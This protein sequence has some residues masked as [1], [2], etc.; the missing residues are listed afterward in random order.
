MKIY[1]KQRLQQVYCTST[2]T[3]SSSNSNDSYCSNR[4]QINHSRRRRHLRRPHRPR[5]I[6]YRGKVLASCRQFVVVVVTVVAA[7]V[8]AK[9]NQSPRRPRRDLG[10]QR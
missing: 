10:P 2:S 5:P 1:H 3:T 6:W 7:P 9:E 4:H 8:V